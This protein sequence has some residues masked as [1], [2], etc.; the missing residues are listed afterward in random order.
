MSIEKR[1]L[2]LGSAEVRAT[3]DFCILA[4]ALTYNKFSPDNQLGPGLREKVAPGCFR[5]SLASGEDVKCLV[6]HNA[7]RI[8]GRKQNGTL[9]LTDGPDSLRFKVQL[10]PKSQAH[11]DVYAS[12]QRGD[13]SECSFAFLVEKDHYEPGTDST[14]KACQT[15]V[16]DKAKLFDVSIV[17]FPFYSDSGSTSAEARKAALAANRT[18]GLI[19]AAKILRRAAQIATREIRRVLRGEM[20]QTDFASLMQHC[21]ESGEY[22]CTRMD[23]CESLMDDD[24]SCNDDMLR[25][26]FRVAQAGAKL[27]C[28]NMA[29]ARLRHYSLKDKKAGADAVKAL[30]RAR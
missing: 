13:L 14:G 8:L 1:I 25:G 9:T 20:D 5:D 23:D 18:H 15:R 10:N 19:E 26:A 6:N 28:E 3:A 11:Q 7:D 24:D 17:T 30:G 2:V 12:V 22:L 27:Y 4:K 29:N 21:H 16:L